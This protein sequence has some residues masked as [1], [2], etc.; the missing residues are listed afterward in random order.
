MNLCY[1]PC[2]C[3]CKQHARLF[4]RHDVYC[5]NECF[6]AASRAPGAGTRKL[7]ATLSQ[8]GLRIGNTYCV[9]RLLQ[10]RMKKPDGIAP[11]GY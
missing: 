7:A 6:T 9:D 8:Y 2:H 4:R 11:P 10:E 5:P 1:L 3:A